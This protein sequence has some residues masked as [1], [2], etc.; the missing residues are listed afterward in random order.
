MYF[1]FT[2]ANSNFAW[3]WLQVALRCWLLGFIF[4]SIVSVVVLR[5]FWYQ[6]RLL[7]QH[8]CRQPIESA[9]KRA[10][11]PNMTVPFKFLP[12]EILNKPKPTL[13]IR[14]YPTAPHE[15]FIPKP[16]EKPVTPPKPM[17]TIRAH[18][19]S[20]NPHHKPK[21]KKKRER[22]K[23]AT[24]QPPASE[25]HKINTHRPKTQQPP[26]AEPIITSTTTM[27]RAAAA[28]LVVVPPQS[29][30][31]SPASPLSSNLLSI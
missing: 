28:F 4:C 12:Y 10:S 27:S 7:V 17:T 19:W 11:Q 26:A 20:Q 31:P 18:L 3:C 5:Q 24:H 23:K 22:E 6:S 13:E 16:T 8:N 9:I 30:T 29:L 15:F 14:I 25:T 21:K 2:S 1:L